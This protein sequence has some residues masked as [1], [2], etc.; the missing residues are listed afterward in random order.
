MTTIRQPT[1]LMTAEDLFMMED[2]AF[3]YDLIDGNVIRMSP[4][5]RE[6]GRLANELGRLVANF[7]I[8]RGLGE[9]YGAETG[10]IL[11]RTPD[12]VLGPDVSFVR[13]ERLTPDLTV[14][15]YLP[16]APDLAVEI[17]S[18]SER[19]GEIQRKVQKYLAAG[20][21]LLVLVYRRRR[22]IIAYRY[23]EPTTLRLGDVL[24]GGDVL[25]GFTVAVA[26]V[27]AA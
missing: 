17:I 5:G 18:P 23:G 20:V 26:D 15:G 19:A 22:E 6:H 12:V 16:L 27:F 2:D 8:P 24:D 21:P 13:R 9:V 3:R 11:R 4:A 1:A 14:E 7:V 10:F 25:P